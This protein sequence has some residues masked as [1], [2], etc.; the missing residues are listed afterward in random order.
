MADLIKQKLGIEASLVEG[1][2]GEFTV[3]V[4]GTVVAK[5]GFVA[6]PSDKKV[7]TAVQN[8]LHA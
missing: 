3:W 6:F 5:K 7:L 8:A 4:G 1:D 2:L